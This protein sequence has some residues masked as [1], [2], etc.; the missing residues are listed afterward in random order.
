MT[1]IKTGNK[2]LEVKFK[3]AFH[4]LKVFCVIKLCHSLIETTSQSCSVT[5][6]HAWLEGRGSIQPQLHHPQN[7]L[8]FAFLFMS[9]VL[10]VSQCT[11]YA[12]WRG[13]ILRG[14]G[15]RVWSR[16]FCHQHPTSLCWCP[17]PGRYKCFSIFFRAGSF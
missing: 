16:R 11:I 12:H 3:T 5:H 7:L 8:H 2:V 14:P 9:S 10:L 6:S 1:P 13:V 15:F 4:V 17:R